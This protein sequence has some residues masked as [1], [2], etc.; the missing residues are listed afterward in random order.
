MF[1]HRTV[2][3]MINE[4]LLLYINSKPLIPQVCALLKLTRPRSRARPELLGEPAE[5]GAGGECTCQDEGIHQ[6]SQAAS[7]ILRRFIK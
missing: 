7:A 2:F 5:A 6:R 1:E 4:K 3:G